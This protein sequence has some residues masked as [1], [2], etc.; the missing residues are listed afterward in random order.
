MEMREGLLT[1]DRAGRP[2]H[3]P[4][5]DSG[6]FRTTAD[7]FEITTEDGERFIFDRVEINAASAL[8][9]ARAKAA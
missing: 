2:E 6:T 1:F 8:P 5:P 3:T 7:M 9:V 4:E